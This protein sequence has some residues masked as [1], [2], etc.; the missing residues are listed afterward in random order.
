VCVCVY[1]CVCVCVCGGGGV[2]GGGGGVGLERGCV[3]ER[4]RVVWG[5]SVEIGVGG[6]FGT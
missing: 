4:G 6:M 5:E 1:V 3:C 2:F